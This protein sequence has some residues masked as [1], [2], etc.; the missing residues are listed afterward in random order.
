MDKESFF[1]FINIL[2]VLFIILLIGG[3]VITAYLMSSDQTSFID[4][5]YSYLQYTT[6]MFNFQKFSDRWLEIFISL[7]VFIILTTYIYSRTI[8]NIMEI[9]N[10]EK[11]LYTLITFLFFHMTYSCISFGIW[12]FISS[13]PDNR[14]KVT[15][16]DLQLTEAGDDDDTSLSA[17]GRYMFMAL[18]V[19]VIILGIFLYRIYRLPSRLTMKKMHAETWAR[20]G[21][22]EERTPTDPAWQHA[23]AAA[24]ERVRNISQNEVVVRE[25]RR[26]KPGTPQAGGRKK[27]RY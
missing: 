13:T 15:N 22:S 18:S 21:L 20:F 16:R 27:K 4:G 10:S 25:G 6:I 7:L 26:N 9:T 5:F 3:N 12:N 2:M 11:I 19:L 17:A 23:E 24:A 14:Y 8:C 1:N